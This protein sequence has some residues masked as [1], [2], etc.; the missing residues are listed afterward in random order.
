MRRAFSEQDIDTLD[1]LLADDLI[2]THSN[3]K[4]ENKA[5]RLEGIADTRIR[6]ESFEREDVETRIL[7]RTAVVT[8]LSTAKLLVEG[9]PVVARLRTLSVWSHRDGR[10]Q[11][12]ASLGARLPD[13]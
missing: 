3:G 5:E 1:A 9:R 10:W 6:Y 4:V 7:G 11:L 13:D 8:G 2:Y 12:V